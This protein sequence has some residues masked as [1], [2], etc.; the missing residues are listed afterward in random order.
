ML[1]ATMV[2]CHTSPAPRP[3]IP[4]LMWLSDMIRLAAG[5]FWDGEGRRLTAVTR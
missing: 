1:I 5:L 3:A 2:I 4:P